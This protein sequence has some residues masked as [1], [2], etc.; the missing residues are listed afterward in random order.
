MKSI[1]ANE[2]VVGRGHVL[3]STSSDTLGTPDVL[4]TIIG[5]MDILANQ[6]YCSNMNRGA[7]HNSYYK[8]I[9]TV[10]AGVQQID[11]VL[12]VALRDRPAVPRG[13]IRLS[14]RSTAQPLYTR[15]SIIF[16]CGCSKVT[17]GFIL[18]HAAPRHVNP[19]H[20][21]LEVLVRRLARAVD[22]Q[23][24]EVRPDADHPRRAT[25]VVVVD[26]AAQ[27]LPRV[28]TRMVRTHGY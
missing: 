22:A 23:A 13:A 9:H 26:K 20:G 19:Q 16:G 28:G 27:G 11:D 1:Q 2:P 4:W 18:P 14:L 10:G 24:F 17:I 6:Y 8:C 3:L 7:Y 15:F 25:Q 21:R 5:S 12:H